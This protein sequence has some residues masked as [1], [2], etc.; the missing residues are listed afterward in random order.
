VSDT[1]IHTRKLSYSYK[2]ASQVKV[3][4]RDVSLEIERGSC[5][6]IIGVTGS[7]KSTLMQHFNGLLKPDTG[8]VWVDGMRVGARGV[9]MRQLR[10]RVGMLFQ[11]PE[12]QLFASTIFADVAFGPQRMGYAHKEVRAKVMAALELVGLPFH[13]YARRSP[14]ELSGGQ[15]RRIALAGVLAMSPQVLILDEPT[16]GLDAQGREELYGCLQ[17]IRRE[18]GGTVILVSHDMA[19]VASLADRLFVLHQGS[20]V[21][22]GTPPEVFSRSEEL[23]SWGLAAPPLHELL[24]LLRKQGVPVPPEVFTLD[25]VYRWFYEYSCLSRQ[26]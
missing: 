25:E 8:A 4:L 14:F 26:I 18:Q 5:V 15:K 2:N 3:A 20:L 10:R 12:S 13:L 1:I 22:Q 19:E 24:A 7:G 17:R 21:M 16:V 9:D 23:R 11:F 6:A